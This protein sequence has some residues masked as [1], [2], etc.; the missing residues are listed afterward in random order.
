MFLETGL[1]IVGDVE[2]SS[3]PTEIEIYEPIICKVNIVGTG[4]KNTLHTVS[5]G[6]KV[7]RKGEQK[8]SGRE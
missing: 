1:V 8:L 2:E 5:G 3:S 6:L 4:K 7:I